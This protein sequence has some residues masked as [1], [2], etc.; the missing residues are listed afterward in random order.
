MARKPKKKLII[1][2]V[3]IHD[4]AVEGNGIGRTADDRVV[5]V[6]GGVP[7]DVADVEIVKKK[8]G[9]YEGVA[10]HFHQRSAYR[11]EP[12]CSHFGTCGGCK[13]QHFRYEVQAQFK[14][15]FVA[16]SLKRIGKVEVPEVLPILKSEET[17]YYRNK[18][19][20][21][22]TDSR[23]L[24]AEQIGS[25]HQFDRRGV[26]FNLPGS[27]SKVLDITHCYL[28]GGPSNDIRLAL[29]AYGL[30]HNL[31][32]FNLIEQDG[33]LRNVMVR[34]TTT[35][36]VMVI[37]QVFADLPDTIAAL[38]RY[39]ER[40][41]PEI[42]SMHY[43]V[44]MK[45]NDTLYDQEVVHA[46]GKPYITEVME[47]LQFRIGPKSFFQTNSKQAYALYKEV[48]DFAGLT[49]KEV[50][51]DLY[52]G[53]GTIA[54]FLA[55]SAREVIGVEYIPEAIADAHINA[56]LNGIENVKFYA[57]DMKDMLNEAFLAEH[58]RPD[59]IVTDP[60]R[61]GMH[62]D[63]NQMLL[64]IAAPK[65]VY[66]SCNPATQ[67]RDLFTLSEKYA[68]QKIRPVDM[69]PHTAHVENIALLTLKP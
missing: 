7:G 4:I 11:T 25:A 56:Q 21:T 55:R 16:E 38:M 69:F 28:Q 59:V 58:T 41:F 65:I 52:T 57:G 62:P 14:E 43:S 30:E 6:K 67:A 9:Y 54:L 32:F 50:V 17:L 26:G 64:R 18:L 34:T 47:G 60:P 53:T 22:F 13:W 33:F 1:E 2:Q 20:F 51:Y 68:V 36:D 27:F 35:G 46:F 5:F 49:G 61:A 44:N 42:T 10:I 8:S 66:V 19:E 24:T 45:A 39:L 37:L 3:P 12:V 31:P 48:R 63:V 23:W 29:K 40:H 15:K